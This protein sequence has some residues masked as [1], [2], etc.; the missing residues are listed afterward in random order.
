MSVA[1]RYYSRS[2]NTKKVADY[3]AEAAGVEAVSVDS[4]DAVLSEKV[5]VLFNLDDL[6]LELV[7]VD[8]GWT[9]IAPVLRTELRE[10]IAEPRIRRQVLV[11]A[12]MDAHFARVVATENWPVMDKNGRRVDD[13]PFAFRHHGHGGPVRRSGRC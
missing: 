4:K 5:D 9:S 1:V 12:E 10:D 3:I 13:I 2:G 11:R 6:E 8:L 7:L